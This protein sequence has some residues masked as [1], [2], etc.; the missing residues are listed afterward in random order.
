MITALHQTYFK[1]DDGVKNPFK[2]FC[3]M[4]YRFSEFKEIISKIN[5]A[6][7]RQKLHIGM[8]TTNLNAVSLLPN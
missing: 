8:N 7:Q 2:Y 6:M 3:L 1:V 5:C 4:C